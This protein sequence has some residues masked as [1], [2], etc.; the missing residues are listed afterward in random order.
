MSMQRGRAIPKEQRIGVIMLSRSG[1]ALM[2]L[3]D[4]GKRGMVTVKSMQRILSAQRPKDYAVI[5]IPTFDK[6]GSTGK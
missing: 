5:K 1:K 2:L 3:L 6:G 4:D